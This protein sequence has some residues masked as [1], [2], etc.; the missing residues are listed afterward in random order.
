MRRHYLL[1]CLLFLLMLPGC[2]SQ[3]EP[4]QPIK[5]YYPKTEISYGASDGVLSHELRESASLSKETVISLYLKG[6]RAE[7]L[8][9]PFP[10][11]INIIHFS[12]QEKAATLVLSD[13]YATLSGLDISIASVCLSKTVMELTGAESVTLSCQTQPLG[14]ETR[15]IISESDLVLYDDSM[16]HVSEGSTPTASSSQ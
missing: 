2:K 6:P 10:E 15:I 16:G 13:S 3:Q 11:N 14:G 8:I 5:F 12:V 9:S 7:G 4:R 1:L